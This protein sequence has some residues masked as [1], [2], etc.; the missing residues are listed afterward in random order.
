MHLSDSHNPRALPKKFPIGT[1][2][3]VEGRGGEAGALQVYSR[4]VVLPGGKRINLVD[5]SKAAAA[6]P[7]APRTRR[8]RR[9]RNAS[10]SGRKAPA[11]AANQAAKKITAPAG[12]PRQGR[13]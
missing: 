11:Q 13:R 12:T 6:R 2:Y 1:T 3:V 8:P 5:D 10:Q 9:A 4:Y 7:A